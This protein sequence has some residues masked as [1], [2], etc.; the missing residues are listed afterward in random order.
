MPS[1]APAAI[2]AATAASIF[3]LVFIIKDL[4]IT[5]ICKIKINSFYKNDGP[6]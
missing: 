3:P 5:D 4:M 2:P 1:T 6:Q